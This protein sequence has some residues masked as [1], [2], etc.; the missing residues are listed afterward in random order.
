MNRDKFKSTTKVMEVLTLM[1]TSAEISEENKNKVTSMLDDL[2][3]AEGQRKL[4]KEYVNEL[5]FKYDFETTL[6]KYISLYQSLTEN[7]EDMKLMLVHPK[8]LRVNRVERIKYEYSLPNLLKI[9]LIMY[10]DYFDELIGAVV[11]RENDGKG[12]D[13]KNENICSIN[14]EI[15]EL[16]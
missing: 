15:E 4:I 7:D 16:I 1:L 6:N 3:I 10:E 13:K 9:R 8:R 11:C 5:S 14:K 2:V 12:L